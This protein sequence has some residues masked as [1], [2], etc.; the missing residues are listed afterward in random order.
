MPDFQDLSLTRKSRLIDSHPSFPKQFWVFQK[1]HLNIF[2]NL[3]LK[4]TDLDTRNNLD[5]TKDILKYTSSL[6]GAVVRE[7]QRNDS[8]ELRR[9]CASEH[10]IRKYRNPIFIRLDAIRVVRRV[11]RR[12]WRR[13]PEVLEDRWSPAARRSSVFDQRTRARMFSARMFS[14]RM[15]EFKGF[16]EAWVSLSKIADRQSPETTAEIPSGLRQTKAA[17]AC[18]RAD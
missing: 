1:D 7:F 17:M 18:I 15:L 9:L 10:P 6:E 3:P 14:A 13:Y 16:E 4:Q 12:V 2:E 8:L 11:W 5:E